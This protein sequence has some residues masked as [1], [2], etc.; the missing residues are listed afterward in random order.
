MRHILHTILILLGAILPSCI[1]DGVI[2][3]PSAQPRFETDTLSLGA[4]FT[5]EGS[6]TASVKIYNPHD[7]ILNISSVRLRDGRYFRINVDGFCGREFTDVE[8]RPN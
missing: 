4:V 1:E 8:I 3:D 6:P 5:G 7:K 2:T